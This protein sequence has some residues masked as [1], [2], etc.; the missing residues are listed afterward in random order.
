MVASPRLELVLE[1]EPV[2]LYM[3]LLQFRSSNSCGEIVD[4]L[5]KTVRTLAHVPTKNSSHSYCLQSELKR[6]STI[7]LICRLKWINIST[8]MVID[9]THHLLKKYLYGYQVC[10]PTLT[11]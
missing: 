1:D 10:H 4:V 3:L 8:S 2:E 6:P 9:R 11:C 5:F 7:N